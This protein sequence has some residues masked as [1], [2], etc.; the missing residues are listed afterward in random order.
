L[1]ILATAYGS[2]KTAVDGIKAGAFDYLAKPFIIDD[3]R[4]VTRR[5]IEHKLVLSENQALREQLK[6][7]YRFEGIVGSSS[8]MVAV[9]KLIAACSDGQHHPVARGERYG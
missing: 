6:E 5:A 3:I 8:G 9:Y 7:R 4:L 1:I 2:L